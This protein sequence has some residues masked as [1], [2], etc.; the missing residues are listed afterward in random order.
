[1]EQY[2]KREEVHSV[3]K[4]PTLLV[5]DENLKDQTDVANAL[6]N[7]FITNTEKPNI[8]QIEKGDALSILKDS[9][10]GN[11]SQHKNNPN[12]WSWDKKYN[13]SPLTK[14]NHQVMM[15]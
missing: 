12:H 7:F 8:Q 1:M 9:F 14:K 3:E 13:T 5:N 6:N 4:V 15:K 10:P 2:K 11:F